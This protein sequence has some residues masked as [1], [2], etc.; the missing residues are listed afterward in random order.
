M[1][2]NMAIVSLAV[3]GSTVHKVG[4]SSQVGSDTGDRRI[5]TEITHSAGTSGVE[6][7]VYLKDGSIMQY[8]GNIGYRALWEKDKEKS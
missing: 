6:Y 5:V 3:F 7:L 4:E 8:R 1:K 2:E